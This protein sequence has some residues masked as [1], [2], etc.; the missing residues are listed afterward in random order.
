MIVI[1]IVGGIASGKSA[2]ANHLRDLGA[3]VLDADAVGHEVLDLPEVITQLTDRWGEAI[4]L[5]SGKLD[6]KKIARIVFRSDPL[7]EAPPFGEQSQEL[8]YLEGVTHGLIE[9]RLKSRIDA[10]H[11]GGRVNAIVLD[12]PVMF[13]AGWNKLCDRIL[14]ID[15]C[16]AVRERRAAGRGWSRAEF[17]AREA[18]QES[19]NVKRDCA[20]WVIDNGHSPDETKAQ[21]QQIWQSLITERP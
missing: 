14:F 4:L 18:A 3:V 20:D 21:I 5:P 19:L 6:R 13:K 12:A 17:E 9:S 2:V 10:Y 1:G 16:R 8:V 7:A 15:A 11:Q